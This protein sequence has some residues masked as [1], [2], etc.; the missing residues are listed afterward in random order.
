MKTLFCNRI[1]LLSTVG[2]V[3]TLVYWCVVGKKNGETKKLKIYTHL[4]RKKRNKSG[5]ND[6]FLH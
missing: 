4:H 2:N 1:Y 5:K 6:V 3:T